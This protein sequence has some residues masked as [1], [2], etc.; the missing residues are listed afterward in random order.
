[1][2]RDKLK[3]IYYLQDSGV[4][5]H[6]ART[7][8]YY[9]STLPN[10]FCMFTSRGTMNLRKDGIKFK[11][12]KVTFNS[13]ISR[14]VHFIKEEYVYTI[15]DSL[16]EAGLKTGMFVGK[17]KFSFIDKSYDY[18]TG[19]LLKADGI[20]E[21]DM[22]YMNEEYKLNKTIYHFGRAIN[23]NRP[24]KI[25]EKFIKSY[26]NKEYDYYFI[27]FKGTDSMG[28]EHGWSSEQY[29]QATIG[30]DHDLGKI[31]KCL[32][33][34][35][36]ETY[37]IMTSDHGG[38]GGGG[39]NIDKYHHDATKKVNFTIP[40]YIWRNTKDFRSKDLY[41]I[42]PQRLNPEP[43]YNPDYIFGKQPIR[44]GDVANYVTKLFKLKPVKDSW[45]GRSHDLHAE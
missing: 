19:I 15:F 35:N 28:H 40:F 17:S 41:V 11:G 14:D 33:D 32:K 22:Y 45:I 10:H 6:N 38:G 20:D 42:N 26:N 1:M 16:K 43:D 36:E 25:V 18:N 29:K 9:T 5:T 31:L 23:E 30:V 8:K 13:N 37:L 2:G 39:I 12:H 4:W 24:I 44:N 34:S 27:H 3:F 21:I 7:D